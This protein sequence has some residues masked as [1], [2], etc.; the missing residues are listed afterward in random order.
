MSQPHK[1]RRTWKAQHTVSLKYHILMG[2]AWLRKTVAATYQSIRFL[3]PEYIKLNSYR[4]PPYG[5]IAPSGPGPSHYRGFTIKRRHTVGL[6]WMSD[7]TNTDRHH[8]HRKEKK[9][10]LPAGFEPTIPAKVRP[11]PRLRPRGHWQ[12]SS[13]ACNSH[14]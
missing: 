14:K 1:Q 9:I 4:R 2:T 7:Q 13:L 6:L 12:Q 11:Y 10:M 8:T 5:A 3:A